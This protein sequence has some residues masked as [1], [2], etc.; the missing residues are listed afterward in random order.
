MWPSLG[1]AI[2]PALSIPQLPIILCLWSRSPELLPS[3]L[4]MFI[5]VI[6][7]QVMGRMVRFHGFS[8]S[9]ISRRQISQKMLCSADFQS[10][11][12]SSEMIPKLSMQELGCRFIRQGWVLQLCIQI[13]CGFLQFCLLQRELLLMIG[14]RTELICGYKKK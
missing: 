2:F 1:K 8:F 13:R 7:V 9:G 12:P 6:I 11:S 5:V 4:R 3:H 14:W 10:S